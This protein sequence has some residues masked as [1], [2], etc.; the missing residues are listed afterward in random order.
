M[1]PLILF[2]LFAAFFGCAL[3]TFF[4]FDQILRKEH[5]DYRQSWEQDG[6]PIGFFWIPEGGKILEGSFARSGLFF[7]WAFSLPHWAAPRTD[8]VPL[9]RELRRT[10]AI[11][12]G[13][14]IVS[15]IVLFTFSS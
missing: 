15:M 11:G 10:L 1:T 5:G 14:W 13:I 2:V 6:K 8:L 4:L 9:F 12:V 7:K 3:R